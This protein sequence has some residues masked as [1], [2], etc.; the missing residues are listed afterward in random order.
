MLHRFFGMIIRLSEGMLRVPDRFIYRF[1]CFAH[2][3]IPFSRVNHSGNYAK[4]EDRLNSEHFSQHRP[5]QAA[6]S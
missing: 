1:H 2:G 4:K 3:S 5:L 6:I